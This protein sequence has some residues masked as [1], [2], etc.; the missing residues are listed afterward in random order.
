MPRR[1]KTNKNEIPIHHEIYQEERRKKSKQRLASGPWSKINTDLCVKAKFMKHDS[2][3]FNFGPVLGVYN[4]C[5]TGYTSGGYRARVKITTDNWEELVKEYGIDNI[6]AACENSLNNHKKLL[7][8]VVICDLSQ[9]KKDHAVC[10]IRTSKK[11]IS[12]FLGIKY[13]ILQVF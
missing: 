4:N 5:D 7:G 1:K 9:E 13:G 10:M 12:R 8:S 11:N 6:L 2:R 3:H